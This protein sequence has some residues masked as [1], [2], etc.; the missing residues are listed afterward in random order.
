VA[1]HKFLCPN[2]YKEVVISVEAVGKVSKCNLCGVS[3]TVPTSAQDAS[4][5]EKL[6]RH[7]EAEA[8]EKRRRKEAEKT[9]KEEE[10][11]QAEAH[12]IRQKE[13]K[14]CLQEEERKREEAERRKRL[15]EQQQADAA[16]DEKMLAPIKAFVTPGA[17]APWKNPWVILSATA[18]VALV[19]TV[20]CILYHRGL[21]AER[22]RLMD[23]CKIAVAELDAATN[24]PAY[25][26][27]LDRGVIAELNIHSV[28]AFGHSKD[29]QE[30]K[31]AQAAAD[32]EIQKSLPT[33]RPA[34]LARQKAAEAMQALEH[35]DHEHVG[36]AQELGY[37]VGE[38]K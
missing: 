29:S 5:R 27:A 25:Q 21:M 13:E 4:L 37:K 36:I 15:E 31:Q 6:K 22:L 34:F 8:E 19:T 20:I 35:F 38:W 2:C 12:R 11:R 28:T 23:Q 17:A 24:D 3:F 16:R 30:Y 18:A 32:E 10:P 7:G 14:L 9:R 33:F 26:T 1:W